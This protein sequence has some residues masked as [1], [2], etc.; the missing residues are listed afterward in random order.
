MPPLCWTLPSVCDIFWYILQ[1]LHTVLWF[2]CAPL[3]VTYCPDTDTL[4]PDNPASWYSDIPPDFCLGDILF[5]FHCVYPV[6]RMWHCVD[7]LGLFTR[8]RFL[9]ERGCN[10]FKPHNHLFVLCDVM[11]PLQL[12]PRL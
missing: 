12:K 8:C 4:F 5:K 3:E 11:Y 2:G 6:H 9:L 10:L 7:F 1:S